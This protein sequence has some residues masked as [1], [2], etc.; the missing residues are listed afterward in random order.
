MK[1]AGFSDVEYGLRKRATKSPRNPCGKPDEKRVETSTWKRRKPAN[2]H[3]L[4]P[5]ANLV[6]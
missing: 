3:G 6:P 1:H 5:L 2:K 4:F